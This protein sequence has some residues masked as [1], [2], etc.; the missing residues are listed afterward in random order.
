ME[1]LKSPMPPSAEKS[2]FIKNTWYVVALSDDVTREPKAIRVCGEPLVLFR[3]EG[4]QAVVMQD[5]CPHRLVPLSK[6]RVVGD[7]IQCAYHG[8]R[9]DCTGKCV[10][11]PGDRRPV[12]R[13][14]RQFDVPVFKSRELHGFLWVWLGDA[15]VGERTPLP[16]FVEYMDMPG[17]TCFRGSQYTKADVSLIIDNLLDLSHEAFLHPNTIGNA[18]VG[19]TAAET[20]VLE[21]SIEVE[22]LMPDCPPPA[23]FREAAGFTGNIDRYQRVV[24]TPASSF[25]IVVRA[26]PVAGTSGDRLEW[27]VHH[28]LTPEE[29]G[30]THYFF[31]LTR[32]FA[33]DSQQ[34]TDTLSAGARRTLKEDHDML[35]AQ[36]QALTSVPLESRRLH[37]MFDGAPNAGRR[38]IQQIAR[39]ERGLAE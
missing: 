23:M 24:F 9:F 10:H 28:L 25:C 15:E 33:L 26:T 21:Q 22:R 7:E 32:N 37:T 13:L 27:F 4:G 17:W 1:P 3:T 29:E 39:K 11:V 36:Q 35:E 18:A 2:E 8:I 34:V 5:R 38:L 20:R 12:E 6:G 19:E 14:P 30:K 16:P 31:S